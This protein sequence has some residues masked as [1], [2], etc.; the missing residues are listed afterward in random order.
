MSPEMDGRMDVWWSSAG[1]SAVDS[2]CTL[3]QF[4]ICGAS[5][6]YQA[7]H[8]DVNRDRSSSKLLYW[9]LQVEGDRMEA[10]HT[11]A[12][13]VHPMHPQHRTRTRSRYHIVKQPASWM[14]TVHH[15]WISA[16]P[17]LQS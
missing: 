9:I 16:A 3:T 12:I 15:E 2:V 5:V 1:T 11:V 14:A 8:C 4:L 10:Q 13:N 17:Q 6:R 7:A